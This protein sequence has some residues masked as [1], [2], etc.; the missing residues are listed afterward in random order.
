M[1]S[2]SRYARGSSMR[3]LQSFIVLLWLFAPAPGIAV[4]VPLT[5]AEAQRLALVQSPLVGARRSA[6]EAAREQAVAAAQMADPVLKVG[7]D[8]LPVNGADAFSL[9]R[10]FMTMGR[11]GLMQEWTRADKREA[12]RE[13]YEREGE[14]AFSQEEATVAEIR[15]DVA[16]AWIDRYYAEAIVASVGE[17]LQEANREV[18][19]AEA[20]FRGGRGNAAEVLQ[21]KGAALALEDRAAEARRNVA[22]AIA[23]LERWVGP[24]AGAPLSGDP[25][26]DSLAFDVGTLPRTL[27]RLPAVRTLAFEA[28]VAAAEARVAQVERD[29]DWS[30][31]I[32]YQQRGPDY[33]NM[34]SI[35]ISVPLP[36]NRAQRQDREVAARLAKLDG[37]RAARADAMRQYS[38]QLRSW[39]AEWEGGRERIALHDQKLV[40]LAKDRTR[41][42]IAAYRGGKGALSE[43]LA[44]RRAELDVHRALLTVE[45]ETARAW[46]QLT[47]LG[48][49]LAP[50]S[51]GSPGS[52]P[53][54]AREKP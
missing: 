20:A 1:S 43:V 7:I 29:P 41:A 5:L 33:S 28:D 27:E 32:A 24:S 52:T 21:A 17:Q 30:F 11:I 46:A 8:N 2:R 10:D 14:R 22:M 40:P 38:A 13:R 51:P 44:A 16:L 54:S 39:F 26:Y 47:Y 23:V 49:E 48:T 12:R 34:M 19:G 18:E 50:A 42:A 53:A 37:A 35:G 31:E 36:W 3:S 25:P 4:E 15:R 6:V 45:Q 9:T